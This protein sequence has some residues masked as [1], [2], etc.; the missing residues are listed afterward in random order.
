MRLTFAEKAIETSEVFTLEMGAEQ[1]HA[2]GYPGRPGVLRVRPGETCD[3]GTCGGVVLDVLKP[4]PAAEAVKLP[5]PPEPALVSE[6]VVAAAIADGTHPF[7]PVT[8]ADVRAA[9]EPPAEMVEAMEKAV[10]DDE[11][12]KRDHHKK[13]R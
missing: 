4:I 11:K 9:G 5:P 6:A 3:N 8:D 12:P 13:H 7:S 1:W 10:E 2:C